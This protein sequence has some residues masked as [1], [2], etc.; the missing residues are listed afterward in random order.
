[1]NY[2][3]FKP[4][5]A[6]GV[7]VINRSEYIISVEG[8]FFDNSKFRKISIDPTQTRLST[9]QNSFSKLLNQG[10]TFKSE[11]SLLRTKH[12]NVLLVELR[13]S[14]VDNTS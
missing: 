14:F 7:V 9:S 10:E 11:Y 13:M 12:T 3:I 5:K 1:M 6:N 4:D 2:S 8:L